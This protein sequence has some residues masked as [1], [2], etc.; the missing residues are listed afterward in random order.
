MQT[1]V[2]KTWRKT[3][4]KRFE[5]KGSSKRQIPSERPPKGCVFSKYSR[6]Q[7]TRRANL[8]TRTEATYP[9]VVLQHNQESSNTSSR[10]HIQFPF[11][12][13]IRVTSSIISAEQRYNLVHVIAR[14]AV[15]VSLSTPHI[16][17]VDI[18]LYDPPSRTKTAID[19]KFSTD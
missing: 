9:G 4:I 12:L 1:W 5:N 16:S 7:G 13:H 8:S 18:T 17:S 14:D 3:A 11:C 15:I 6:K 19:A 2:R 10:Q